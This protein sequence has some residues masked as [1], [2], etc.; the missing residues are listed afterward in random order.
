VDVGVAK[1]KLLTRRVAVRVHPVVDDLRRAG[2]VVVLPHPAARHPVVV[3]HRHVL[4]VPRR[5]PEIVVVVLV[6]VLVVPETS[7]LLQKFIEE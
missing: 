4:Q 2:G 6:I 5:P 1:A 7:R 3:E